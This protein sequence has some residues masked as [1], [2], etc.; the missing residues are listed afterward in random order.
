MLQSFLKAGSL[1]RWVSRAD[2]PPVIKEIKALFERSYG[3]RVDVNNEGL[4]VGPD[5]DVPEAVGTS[6]MPDDLVPLLGQQQIHIHA[7]L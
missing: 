7:R 2:C 4:C 3:T 5:P 1:R 6:R